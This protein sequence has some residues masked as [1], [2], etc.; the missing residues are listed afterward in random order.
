MPTIFHS[1]SQVHPSFLEPELIL[2]INQA[3]GAFETLADGEPRVKLGDEDQYVYATR[4][5]LRT[6]VASGQASY[7][8]LPSCTI[9]GTK[10]S[11]GTYNLRTRAEYDHHDTAAAS[12]YGVS[13]V[14]AQRLGCRQGIFQLMRNGLLFGYNPVNGEGLLNGAG[15]TTVSLP[16]DTFGATTVTTYDNGQMGVFLLGQIQLIKTRTMQLGTPREFVILGPQRVLSQ[17]EYSGIVQLVQFQ[18]PGAGT[19]STA[20]VVKEVLMWNGDRVLWAYDDTLIAKGSG[21]TSSANV[22]AVL[23]VMP[24]VEPRL[25]MHAINT[26]AFAG[27]QPSMAACTLMYANM[28]APREIPT[29]MPG[30]AIDVLFELRSSSG[31]LV[32]PESTTVVSMPYP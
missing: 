2:Q 4:V 12:N 25:Q 8:S 19:T 15:I 1:W 31:W 24:Q 14:D 28:A 23:I 32:R 26:N 7:N 29:P 17:W 30:G 5:D 27:L 10:F 18:R 21:S 20:G 3:S 13:I 11:T 9:T 22:D 16:A 6:S